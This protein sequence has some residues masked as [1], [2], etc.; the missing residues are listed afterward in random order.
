MYEIVP[1]L[2]KKGREFAALDLQIVSA[3]RLLKP[4][5]DSVPPF[6]AFQLQ[7]LGRTW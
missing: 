1:E 4:T 6:D 7:T 2:H 3:I 5:L